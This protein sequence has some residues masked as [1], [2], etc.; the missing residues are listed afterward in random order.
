M[1]HTVHDICVSHKKGEASLI[2]KLIEIA[3][4]TK[5]SLSKKIPIEQIK[6]TSIW[7]TKY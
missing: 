3:W 4:S 2:A 1:V 5:I 6:D 7:H